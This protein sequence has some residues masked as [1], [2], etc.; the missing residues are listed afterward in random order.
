MK[1]L[2]V[3]LATDLHSLILP[4]CLYRPGIT[5][6]MATSPLS[7]SKPPNTLYPSLLEGYSV[8]SM[9]DAPSPSTP[10][11]LSDNLDNLLPHALQMAEL[12]HSTNL[13][14]IVKTSARGTVCVYC[15]TCLVQISF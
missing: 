8:I 1:C 4:P 13:D 6:S 2:R 15:T 11:H 7:P 14:G 9:A 5:A 10:G 3:T 12:L